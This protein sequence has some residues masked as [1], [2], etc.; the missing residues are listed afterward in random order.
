MNVTRIGSCVEGPVDRD[1]S[2][3]VMPMELICV[4]ISAD[5]LGAAPPPA[6]LP[7]ERDRGL[8]S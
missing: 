4:G 3:L 8:W 1:G 6:Q 5:P 2:I 7:V